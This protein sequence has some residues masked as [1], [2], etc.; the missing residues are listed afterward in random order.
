MRKKEEGVVIGREESEEERVVRGR[1]KGVKEW[2]RRMSV[3]V[4]VV[5]LQ[6]YCLVIMYITNVLKRLCQSIMRV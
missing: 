1:R 4:E 5:E 2:W 3:I 6:E